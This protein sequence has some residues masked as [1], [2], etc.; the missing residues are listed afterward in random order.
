[1][2]KLWSDCAGSVAAYGA[3]FG[4]LAVGGGALAID[5]GRMAIFNTELQNAADASAMAAAVLLDG[6]DGSRARAEAVARNAMTQKTNMSDEGD[7]A[8]ITVAGVSFYKSY[9]PS[10]KVPATSDLDAK[11]VEVTLNG[12]NV[13]YMLKPVL[14]VVTGSS[15]TSKNMSARAAAG[16]QPYV[17]HAPPLMMCDLTEEDPALDPT[18]PANIGRQ[19]RLK[20]PVAGGGTWVP[21]NFGL[22]ALPDGSSGASDIE[23]ALAAVTPADCYQIDVLTATGSKTTKVQNGINARFDVGPE[24]DPPAPNVIN[25]P[26]DDELVA[27][28]DARIGSGTYDLAGYWA[29]KHPSSPSPPATVQTRYQLYLYEQGVDFAVNGSQTLYPVSGTLP[30]GFTLVSPTAADIPVDAANPT[31][32]DFDGVPQDSPASNG[33]LRRLVKVALLQCIADDINGAGTY[34][35][36]GRYVEMF[37]T[38]EV[39]DPPDA[40]IYGE[41]VRAITAITSPEYHANVRLLPYQ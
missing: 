24:P 36:N 3:I 2:R 37:I 10:G 17:C 9:D 13:D 28:P 35:T 1:M 39:R 23:G 19:V 12:K 34:P 16:T 21:G 20:E 33:P 14:N 8:P 25:Y 40:A 22:L 15:D 11:F 18:D 5:Y 27:D 26:L 41:I 4:T 7:G 31:D 32:P 30:A 6:K 29:A 38:Q